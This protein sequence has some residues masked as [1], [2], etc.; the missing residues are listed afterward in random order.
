MHMLT[1]YLQCAGRKAAVV[2]Q[3]GG[4]VKYVANAFSM[5]MVRELPS[6]IHVDRCE[7]EDV[8]SDA[9]SCIGHE[10]T[11][12]VLSKLL[13]REVPARRMAVLLNKG[14][15]LYLVAM[16]DKNGRP[17]RPPEGVVL[18]VDDLEGLRLEWRRIVVQ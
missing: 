10:S 5:N 16:F 17:F 18:G 4:V 15:E 9:V 12:Q 11:A 1:N 2:P 13:G 14:D 7:A 3:K 8:P 6:T